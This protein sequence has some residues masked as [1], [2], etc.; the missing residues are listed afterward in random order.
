[1]SGEL[2]SSVPARRVNDDPEDPMRE[3]VRR[4]VLHIIGGIDK[5][6]RRIEG[7]A[8]A[9]A[10]HRAKD[11]ADHAALV[12]RVSLLERIVKWGAGIA[13]TIL[14]ALGVSHIK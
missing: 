13:A 8:E 7:M 2:N 6:G 9:F 3:D 10:A 1:M 11:E 5:D 14:A 4:L 12:A